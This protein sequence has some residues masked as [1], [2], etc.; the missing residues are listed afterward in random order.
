MQKFSLGLEKIKKFWNT[1]FW[2]FSNSADRQNLFLWFVRGNYRQSAISWHVC[3]GQV[4]NASISLGPSI[5]LGFEICLC[6]MNFFGFL[7][8]G[9]IRMWVWLLRVS[10]SLRIWFFVFRESN[11]EKCLTD[12]GAN[13]VKT[14]IT[15]LVTK[16]WKHEVVVSPI[17]FTCYLVPG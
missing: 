14:S 6:Y 8:S 10:V 12:T 11:E 17:L 15:N 3:L 13:N 2:F 9:G 1:L 5:I 16:S 4:I 7:R